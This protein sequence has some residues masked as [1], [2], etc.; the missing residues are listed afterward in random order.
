MLG[1]E[2]AKKGRKV[3]CQVP[4]G[5]GDGKEIRSFRVVC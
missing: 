5:E 1:G 4:E 2:G 3:K